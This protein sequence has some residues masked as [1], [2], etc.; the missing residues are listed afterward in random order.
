MA[1]IKQRQFPYCPRRAFEMFENGAT[2]ADVFRAGVPNRLGEPVAMRGAY[3]WAQHYFEFKAGRLSALE[4]GEGDILYA[5]SAVG[6]APK[7]EVKQRAA[8]RCKES[9][10][11][12]SYSPPVMLRAAV[13]DIEVMDLFGAGDVPG[14]MVCCSILPLD[15]DQPITLALEF[16]DQRNDRRLLVATLDELA[17]FDIL[18][19]HNIA[20]FDLNWLY[21]RVV[22][23]GLDTP[24]T[25]FYYD[26]YSAAQ[27]L[28]LNVRKSMAE[29]G[30]FM[31]LNE[32][33]S[34]AS[35]TSVHTTT[36]GDIDSPD[37][38]VFDRALSYIIDHCE[39]DVILNRLLFNELWRYD[40]SK[41]LK[42]TKW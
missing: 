10:G 7:P 21:T 40:R 28:A 24:P 35:K 3:R 17:K 12:R 42:R 25:W 30:D 15:E 4:L 38:E 36:W 19:G 11:H 31:R 39:R 37:R 22:Y 16:D 20:R 13:F 1:D 8:P 26:T 33:H 27:R 34:S 29:L 41:S 32:L 5:N 2:A 9:V 18:I 6:S 23:Y 14:H